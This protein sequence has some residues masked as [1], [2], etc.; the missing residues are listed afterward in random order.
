MYNGGPTPIVG[1]IGTSV[2][3]T[4]GADPIFPLTIAILSIVIGGLLIARR[5][6]ITRTA[7][8]TD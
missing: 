6:W 2:L 8:T 4:T 1:G 7:P 3:A 5:R